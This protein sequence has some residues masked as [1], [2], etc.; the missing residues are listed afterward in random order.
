MCV[1][2]LLMERLAKGEYYLLIHDMK[3]FDHVNFFKHLRMTPSKF[4]ELLLFVVPMIIRRTARAILPEGRLCLTLRYLITGGAQVT[5]ASS[6]RISPNISWSY[7]FRLLQ[8]NIV[9]L[10]RQMVFGS[11]KRPR[12][13]ES[14]IIPIRKTLEFSKLRGRY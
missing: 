4:Q 10:N 7:D 9:N 3:S 5:V 12:P 1:R 13:L 14:N 11:A 8:S 6:Y 2:P